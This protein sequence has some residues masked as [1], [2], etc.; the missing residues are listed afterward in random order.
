MVLPGTRRYQEK[1]K[2]LAKY[3]KG[4]IIDPYKNKNNDS[5]GR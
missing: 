2:K 4:K 1:M 5:R 3:Q